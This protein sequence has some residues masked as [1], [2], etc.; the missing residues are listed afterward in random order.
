MDIMAINFDAFEN[1][2]R[3]W[4]YTRKPSKES[5]RSEEEEKAKHEQIL[6]L[7]FLIPRCI[8]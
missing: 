4:N 8:T 3:G 2:V 5:S 7:G 6:D 1:Q